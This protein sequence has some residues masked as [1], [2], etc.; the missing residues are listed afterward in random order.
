MKLTILIK[1]KIIITTTVNLTKG[2]KMSLELSTHSSATADSIQPRSVYMFSCDNCPAHQLLGNPMAGYKIYSILDENEEF[3]SFMIKIDR[4]LYLIPKGYVGYSPPAKSF[5][6]LPQY[7]AEENFGQHICPNRLLF[8]PRL[9]PYTEYAPLRK[10]ASQ[11][12]R[13]ASLESKTTTDEGT[14]A[15]AS[16]ST[17]EIIKRT[18][19]AADLAFRAPVKKQCVTQDPRGRLKKDSSLK[20]GKENKPCTVNSNKD[21]TIETL[22]TNLSQFNLGHLKFSRPDALA[23]LLAPL[24]EI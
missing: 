11:R 20:K 24:R 12:P 4:V 17:Y 23:R 14:T 8:H 16:E 15:L 1:L 7:E 6:T 18:G 9:D 5:F 3:K 21:G 22:C 19:E 2:I 10:M 13:T